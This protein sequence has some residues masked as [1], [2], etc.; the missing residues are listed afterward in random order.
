MVYFSVV[1][2]V[3]SRFGMEALSEKSGFVAER[4]LE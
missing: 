4:R 1:A 3:C 2:D